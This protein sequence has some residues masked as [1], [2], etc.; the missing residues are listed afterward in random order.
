MSRAKKLVLKPVELFE[1]EQIELADTFV[2]YDCA[3]EDVAL[4][5]TVAAGGLAAVRP[6]VVERDS[7]RLVYA[8]NTQLEE[9]GALS[10]CILLTEKLL[11][12]YDLWKSEQQ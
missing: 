6:V 2:I 3:Q 9:S 5:R 4:R 11:M 12:L 7:R 10:R 8:Y 1:I